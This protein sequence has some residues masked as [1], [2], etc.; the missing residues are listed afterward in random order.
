MK[1]RKKTVISENAW[2]REQRAH[3]LRAAEGRHG[4]ESKDRCTH[5]KRRSAGERH[6]AVHPDD[7]AGG[8]EPVDAEQPGHDREACSDQDD[9]AVVAAHADDRQRE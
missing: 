8:S 6:E 5:G 1:P 4:R 7:D 3:A 2:S 9:A